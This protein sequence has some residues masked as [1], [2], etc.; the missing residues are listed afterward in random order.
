MREPTPFNMIAFVIVF[1]LIV[2]GVI[3]VLNALT[4]AAQ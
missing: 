4:G 2:L 1:A 3:F